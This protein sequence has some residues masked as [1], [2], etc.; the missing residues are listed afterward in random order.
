MFYKLTLIKRFEYFCALIVFF[1]LSLAQS[2]NAQQDYNDIQKFSREEIR[3]MIEEAHKK[4][5]DLNVWFERRRNDIE[6]FL[7]LDP[8]FLDKGYC[9]KTN[10]PPEPRYRPVTLIDYAYYGIV[11]YAKIR[12]IYENNAEFMESRGTHSR[13]IMIDNVGITFR[14]VQYIYY[15]PQLVKENCGDS[16]I[17]PCSEKYVLEILG[18]PVCITKIWS[19]EG[20]KTLE[21]MQI[22]AI[23][24]E[25]K[26]VKDAA[27]YPTRMEIERFNRKYANSFKVSATFPSSRFGGQFWASYGVT[28]E[29]P[30]IGDYTDKLLAPVKSL[31]NYCQASIDEAKNFA[32]IK[33][34][35]KEKP[36]SDREQIPD[37]ISIISPDPDRSAEIKTGTPEEIQITCEYG[38][39]S[40]ESGIMKVEAKADKRMLFSRNYPVKADK[41]QIKISF[42]VTLKINEPVM[43]VTLE[44]LPEGWQS[45]P[46]EFLRYVGDIG[47]FKV[48]LNYKKPIAAHQKN[49]TNI[50]ISVT[51]QH[52]LPISGR[53]FLVT[54]LALHI[55]YLDGGWLKR[56]GNTSVYMKTD[57]KGEGTVIYIPPSTLKGKIKVWADPS[58]YF[59]ASQKLEL[60]D[61]VDTYNRASVEIPLDS[62][63]PKITKLAVPGGDLAGTWQKTA[64]VVEISDAD[65][66]AFTVIVWGNGEFGYESGHG[67][68]DKLEVKNVKSP[69]QFRF[70]TQKLGLDL[71]DLPN[72]LEEFTKTNLKIFMRY[73]TLAGGKKLLKASWVRGAKAQRFIRTSKGVE[74]PFTAEN[75]AKAKDG[76]FSVVSKFVTPDGTLA[77][78]AVDIGDY[79]L[80]SQKNVQEGMAAYANLPKDQ[81]ISISMLNGLH[82]TIGLLDTCQSFADLVKGAPVDPYTEALKI[83]YENAKNFY[84]I[85]RKF[86]DAAE[87]WEDILF[88]PIIVEVKDNEGH[89]TRRMAK[90]GVKFSRKAYQ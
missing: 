90:Y 77:T 17:L 21:A 66:D 62:P 8:D 1:L 39:Y 72:I 83:L 13:T 56:S 22:A 35:I 28:Q 43:S 26:R 60:S 50:T 57:E 75:L 4:C 6:K 78:K 67:Y 65:S 29:G 68:R 48:S 89:S 23:E 14:S 30:G 79:V 32:K 20:K 76:A 64:S 81:K 33:L 45:G 41:K 31:L 85:H 38:L 84:Q 7:K 40:A 51:D 11:N 5:G 36:G 80:S 24:A 44:L 12:W 53:E 49:K 73:A 47:T 88:M 37:Y 52:G 61:M 15:P 63:Y 42:P 2:G 69:F 27:K 16:V 19:V 46:K 9:T 55:P 87:S 70:K 58:I 10:K 25:A 86:Q 54:T 3:S 74:L 59:P 18:I 82:T 71:N 34:G